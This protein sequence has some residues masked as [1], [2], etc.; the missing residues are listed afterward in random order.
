MIP[1]SHSSL[2]WTFHTWMGVVY[3]V[4]VAGIIVLPALRKRS[5]ALDRGLGRPAQWLQSRVSDKFIKALMV[6]LTAAA[7]GLYAYCLACGFRGSLSAGEHGQNVFHITAKLA[8]RVFPFFVMGCF[9]AGLIEKYFR[10]GR[11]PIPAS[12]LGNGVFAA[13]IP[14]CSCAAV[15]LAQSMM[16]L[17]RIRVRAVITFLMV[18]PILNPMIIPLSWGVLGGEYLALRILVTFA[19]AMA[20]GIFIE[21]WAGIQQE[22]E[23]IAFSCVGCSKSSAVKPEHAGSALMLGWNTMATLLKYMLIGVAIGALFT[24]YLPPALVGKYLS[25]GLWGLAASALLGIPLYICAGE[26]VV[27][28]SPLMEMG[29]PMGHAIAFTITGNAICITSISI[30]IPAFGRKA[31]L[32]MMGALFFGSLAAGL[33]IN[34]FDAVLPWLTKITL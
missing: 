20:A 6:I 28:L 5:A 18:A 17:H 23:K 25:N 30:L 26:E 22:G 10:A 31:T 24:V 12:M 4:L 34:S 3:L 7:A 2:S 21:R 9:L 33:L 11:I 29:L 19:L 15:P 1:D 14:I 27:I 32:I 8:M 13:L 16:H